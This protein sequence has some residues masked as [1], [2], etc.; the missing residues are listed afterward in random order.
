MVKNAV[1]SLR[2]KDASILT[3]QSLFTIYIQCEYSDGGAGL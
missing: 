1:Y 2:R 3:L